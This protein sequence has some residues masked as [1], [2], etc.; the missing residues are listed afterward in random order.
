MTDT[1]K[2]PHTE[3]EAKAY[4]EG[5]RK[6]YIDAMIACIERIIDLAEE[7]EDTAD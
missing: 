2:L 7:K 5:Y 1:I 6:G 4:A 3:L